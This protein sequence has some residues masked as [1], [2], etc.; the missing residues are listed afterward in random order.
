MKAKIWLNLNFVLLLL[1][2]KIKCKAKWKVIIE[3]LFF[4]SLFYFFINANNLNS[5]IK[6]WKLCKA[7]KNEEEEE[8]ENYITLFFYLEKNYFYLWKSSSKQENQQHE[9]RIE[10]IYF[11]IV[12]FAFPFLL[13]LHNKNNIFKK[14]NFHLYSRFFFVKFRVRNW[15]WKDFLKNKYVPW[16]RVIFNFRI[17][18]F[19]IFKKKRKFL[20]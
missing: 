17:L 4:A 15:L 6:E 9:N 14:K 12:Y 1:L 2:Y 20:L 10:N 11:M 19:N 18:F 5:K 13:L 7:R 8:E 3:I 16:H